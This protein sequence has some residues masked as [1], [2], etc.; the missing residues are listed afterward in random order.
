M[1]IL[2]ERYSLSYMYIYYIYNLLYLIYIYYY[3]YVYIY[4]IC[5][6]I[7]VC[8]SN[9][10]LSKGVGLFIKCALSSATRRYSPLKGE[11]LWPISHGSHSSPMS[12]LKPELTGSPPSGGFHIS[13][14]HRL[15]LVFAISF[16]KEKEVLPNGNIITLSPVV[17]LW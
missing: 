3:L 9:A 11:R 6:Y 15:R 7:Y 12:W 10:P 5:I 4:S 1:Y 16:Y 8:T 13:S 14:D 2:R 17:T